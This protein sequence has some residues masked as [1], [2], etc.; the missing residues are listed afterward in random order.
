MTVPSETPALP[1]LKRVEKSKPARIRNLAI[2]GVVILAAI[3]LYVTGSGR[4]QP[5]PVVPSAGIAGQPDGRIRITNVTD[6]A[7]AVSWVSAGPTTGQLRWGSSP[8][9]MTNVTPDIR[10]ASVSSRT[11]YVVIPS[12]RPATTYYL[13][14]ISGRTVENLNGQ[15]YQVTTGPA[16]G[17]PGLPVVLFGQ[18]LAPDGGAP[19]AGAIIYVRVR[20]R[21][22]R[23]TPGDSGELSAITDDDGSWGLDLNARVPDLK[24]YFAFTETTDEVVVDVEAADKGVA[25]TVLRIATATET[26]QTITLRPKP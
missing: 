18:V 3:A 14:A 17:M 7:F 15:P 19:V 5:A 24:G 6:V 23:G 12:L 2:V 8:S 13:E 1:R 20:D 16:I 26:E 9:Q 10:G 25:S 22:G 11:H 4:P 21:D